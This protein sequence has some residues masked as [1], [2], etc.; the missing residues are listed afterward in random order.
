VSV[1]GGA[2]LAVEL[3]RSFERAFGC[4]IL[5]GDGLSETSP[6]ACFNHPDR[7]RK[8]GAIGTPVKGVETRHVGNQRRPVPAGKVGEVG[9]RGRNV[10]K[11]YFNHPE[12]TAEAIDSE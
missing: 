5:E 4:V 3:L 9:I 8:P 7:E 2:A 10:M 12:A 11:G 1:S 6:V